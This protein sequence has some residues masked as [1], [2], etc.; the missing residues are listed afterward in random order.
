M[1]I[2]NITDVFV[3]GLKGNVAELQDS[4]VVVNFPSL[5]R[6]HTFTAVDFKR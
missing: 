6:N 1:L 5:N 2:R 3:N 4:S